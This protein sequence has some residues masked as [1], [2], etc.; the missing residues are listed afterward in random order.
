MRQPTAGQK[1]TTPAA[2]S[3][4]NADVGSVSQQDAAPVAPAKSVCLHLRVRAR[5]SSDFACQLQ[6]GKAKAA[7]PPAEARVSCIDVHA[8][9]CPAVHVFLQAQKSKPAASTRKMAPPAAAADK[10][11]VSSRGPVG[12]HALASAHCYLQTAKT[13][14][15][16]TTKPLPTPAT[17]TV[18][19]KRV[20]LAT[21]LKQ[22]TAAKS[23][24]AQKKEAAK[25]PVAPPPPESDMDDQVAP[26][27]PKKSVSRVHLS[28]HARFRRTGLTA[29]S[30]G[31]RNKKETVSAR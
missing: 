12:M 10:P 26:A 14:P 15:A 2:A 24:A 23:T 21:A 28:Q 9:A 31:P 18:E 13:V 1:T 19:K 27:V 6:K 8:H 5:S 29:C 4:A 25:K 11:P 16:A 7:P 20:S 30:E 17:Q 3:E 22:V